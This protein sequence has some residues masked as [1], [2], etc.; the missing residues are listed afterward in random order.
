MERIHQEALN[1]RGMIGNVAQ[2][3]FDLMGGWH[4]L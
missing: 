2:R 1:E 3:L 4:G